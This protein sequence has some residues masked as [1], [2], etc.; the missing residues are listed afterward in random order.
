MASIALEVAAAE[1]P[2]LDIVVVPGVTAA[3]AA[4]GLLG[5]PLGHDHAVI[6][7]S[8]L[9]TPWSAIERRLRAAAEADFVIAIYNPRSNTRQRQFDSAWSI[10]LEYRAPSTPVGI[11]AAAARPDERLEVTTLGELDPAVVN[12]KTCLIVG[13]STTR[14]LAGRMVTPRGF[15]S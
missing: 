8:D 12:M 3:Q 13:S 6:S 9:L 5:A 2:A 1:A 15:E 4:A 7:L 11:V 14:V 10:L